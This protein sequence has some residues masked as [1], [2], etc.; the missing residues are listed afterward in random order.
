MDYPGDQTQDMNDIGLYDKAAM[1]F[2]YADIV[3]VET[4][5]KYNDDREASP[6]ATGVDYVRRS[7]ASA[8]SGAQPIGGN[9]YSTYNDKYA[10]LGHVQRAPGVER[11]SRRSAGAASARVR[12]STT[13]PSAT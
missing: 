12:T 6:G 13:W 8:A 2:G 5:M 4:N 10:L 7:T 1:R 3:D 11:R 9:H